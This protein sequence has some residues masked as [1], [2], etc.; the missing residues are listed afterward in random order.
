MLIAVDGVYSAGKSTM[1]ELLVRQ[2][3]RHWSRE[4]LVSEW[5]SSEL[6][7]QHIPQWK[8]DG[9]LGA[10]SLL[11][12]EATDLAHRTETVI[13]PHLAAGGVVVADRYAASGMARALIRGAESAVVQ[14]A[15]AFAPAETMTVLVECDA[16]TTL[17]RR[18]RLGKVLD[19]YH[20]GRDYRQGLSINDDFVDYQ[21]S[22]AALYRQLIP[23][24]GRYLTVDTT[25]TAAEDVVKQIMAHLGASRHAVAS[26]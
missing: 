2:I 11:F 7:G 5:N 14:A 4:V 1:I 12:A 6:V 20:S 25:A 9:R 10:Y 8:R 22:M 3:S 15:F 18:T 13:G 19:G 21:E 24:R 17:R 16:A 26:A 23:Q